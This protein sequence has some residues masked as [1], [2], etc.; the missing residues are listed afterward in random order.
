MKKKLFAL[1]SVFLMVTSILSTPIQVFAETIE[2]DALELVETE[3]NSVMQV[4]GNAEV[5]NAGADLERIDDKKEEDISTIMETNLQAQL[6]DIQAYADSQDKSD[7]LTMTS[8][9]LYYK[10]SDDKYV[11][12][13]EGDVL[14]KSDS[15]KL[16]LAWIIEEAYK[17]NDGDTITVALPEAFAFVVPAMPLNIRFEGKDIKVGEYTIDGS[18]L[19]IKFDHTI[20]DNAI[21]YIENGFFELLGNINLESDETLKYEIGGALLPEFTIG[22]P[23]YKDIEGVTKTFSKHGWQRK[24]KDE[25][26]WEIYV[27]LNNVF[28]AYNNKVIEEENKLKNAIMVDEL[29]EGLSILN[30]TE[31]VVIN[32]PV[33]MVNAASDSLT[34]WYLYGIRVKTRYISPAENYDDTYMTVENGYP[35][36]YS[37]FIGEDGRQTLIMN[38]GDLPSLNGENSL[39]LE[40][41]K[42]EILTAVAAACDKNNISDQNKSETIKRVRNLFANT[43]ETGIAG[44][45]ITFSTSVSDDYLNETEFE[46]L[47]KLYCNDNKTEDG[48]KTVVFERIEGGGTGGTRKGSVKITKVDSANNALRLI[49][50]E[51]E[52][53]QINADKEEFETSGKTDENGELVFDNL[54]AGTYRIREKTPPS[55]YEN[56]NF[57]VTFTVTP[58][59]LIFAYEV[60]NKKVVEKNLEEPK[61]E[62]DKSKA[63][64]QKVYKKVLPKTGEAFNGYHIFLGFMVISFSL[65]VYLKRKKQHNSFR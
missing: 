7:L 6:S 15:I 43:N 58:T 27:G 49:G 17:I 39:E 25:I 59:E 22:P 54:V 11:E 51:F 60:Q 3:K 44:A 46:N 30:P 19:K 50:A 28:S 37:I 29:P 24:N 56:A 38:M 34:N 13:K 40:K 52:L 10:D 62:G 16:E 26:S 31:Q 48:K 45:Y 23:V 65:L 14:K 55:G 9:K 42:T 35:G 4:D 41:T 33:Y 8:V 47:A 57:E 20:Q 64:V 2:S 5:L 21:Q 63:T 32:I 53:Y 36:D 1:F 61:A 18:N 12:V